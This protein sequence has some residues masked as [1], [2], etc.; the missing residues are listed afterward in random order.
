MDKKTRTLF[1]VFCTRAFE[2]RQFS[3]L[4]TNPSFSL[5]GS[6]G[7]E[8][9]SVT[10]TLPGKEQ[11]QAFSSVLRKFYSDRDKLSFRKVR[12]AARREA[13][14][15]APGVVSTLDELGRLYKEATQQGAVLFKIGNRSYS[16]PEL[17]DLWFNAEIIHCDLDKF[18]EWTALTDGLLEGIVIFEILVALQ[19]T[20][21][22]VM[23][24]ANLIQAN[25]L[26]QST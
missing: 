15:S 24:L 18:R 13:V 8:G 3:A 10:T 20:A 1:E 19:N 12:N 4:E 23:E 22:V 7:I 17:L 2:L 26:S 9:I 25:L 14:A 21:S 6:I 5:K 16:V 11:L